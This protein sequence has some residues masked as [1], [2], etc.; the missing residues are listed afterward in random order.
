MSKRQ[1]RW[2][3]KVF[4]SMPACNMHEKDRHPSVYKR[5]GGLF[6]EEREPSEADY[7]TWMRLS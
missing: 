3:E 5:H 7:Q 6:E 4:D 2:C 1:C